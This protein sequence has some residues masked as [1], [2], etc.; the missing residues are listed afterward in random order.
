MILLFGLSSAVFVSRVATQAML[1]EI[2][3]RGYSLGVSLAARTADP[4]LAQD[5]LRLKNMVDEVLDS[6]DDMIY[7]F[8]QD[9][10]GQVLSHTFPA[11]FPVEL[12][13][14]NAIPEGEQG[15]IQL[16]ETDD[17]RVYDFALAVVVGP[18]RIGVVRLGLSQI[19]AQAAVSRLLAIVFGVS[20][21]AALVAVLLGTLFA[22]TAPG[23][24]APVRRRNCH[25]ES[26]SPDRTPFQAE[27]LGDPE[28]H[29]DPMP[30]LWRL[31]AALLVSGRN[32]VSGM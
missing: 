7:A 4:L 14:A 17:E 2:K 10:K 9:K 16:L 1:G 32:H 24:A 23:P 30:G 13:Q 12:L 18:E 15:H 6:S 8:I 3:K 27:L 20:A 21:G 11:G 26:G 28:L 19:K 25:G 22:D 31:P 29:S 5:F